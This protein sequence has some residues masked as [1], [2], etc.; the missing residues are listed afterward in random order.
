MSDSERGESEAI[1]LA[2]RDIEEGLGESFEPAGDGWRV[3]DAF[4]RDGEMTNG[5]CTAVPWEYSCRHSGYFLGLQP[6]GD[7]FVIDGVTIVVR[8]VDGDSPEIFHRY[9][10]WATVMANLGMGATWRPTLDVLP[11][12]R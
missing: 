1:A 4:V 9:I 3:I 2:R 7:T 11:R 10:D 6:T 5:R 12:L 8:D